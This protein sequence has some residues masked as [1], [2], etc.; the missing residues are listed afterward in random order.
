MKKIFYLLLLMFVFLL[1][2]CSKGFEFTSYKNIDVRKNYLLDTNTYE[3]V[4]LSESEKKEVF[5]LVNNL[6][7][8]ERDDI[9]LDIKG[10]IYQIIIDEKV[11]SFVNGEFVYYEDALYQ[12]TSG[13]NELILYFES[14]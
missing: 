5:D 8:K 9:A 14:K 3:E 6:K 11:I 4:V 12:I 7:I 13:A 2:G 1:S 10:Y